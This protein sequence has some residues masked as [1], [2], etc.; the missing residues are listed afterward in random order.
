MGVND[1]GER[2]LVKS[3]LN[4]TG[5]KYRLLP[6]IRRLF[7]KGISTFIDLFCGGGDVA[8]NTDSRRVVANDINESVFGLLSMF[9]ETETDYVFLKTQQLIRQ[10]GL[11]DVSENG[12]AYY[13]CESGSGLGKYNSERYNKMRSD[14]N[15]TDN[16]DT[17]Y[18]IMLYVIILFSFNNQIRFNSDGHFNMP[19]GKR[20]FNK[21]AKDKLFAFMNR[22]KAIDLTLTNKDFRMFDMSSLCSDD[23]V[24]CDPPYLITC[25]TYN[26]N[27]GW[28]QKDDDDLYD[29]LDTLDRKG[30]RFAMS[31]VFENKGKVNQT[32]IKWS[33]KY[34]VAH[35]G[36]SYHNC[37]YHSLDKSENSTDEV[38][39]MNYSIEDKPKKFELF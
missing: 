31:N 26:E 29:I 9:Y 33:A 4:Y 14:F 28:T 1:M 5:G 25:A 32:L 35:L 7:P 10:Y 12:Y 8:I 37:N 23:F 27:G 24:Y 18:W 20:D 17:D 30:I 21:N 39:I 11:S 2:N 36:K 22:I 38:M 34:N 16:K 19:V 13:G 6:Q 15:S 3:P